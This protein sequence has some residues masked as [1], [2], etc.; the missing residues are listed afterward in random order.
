LTVATLGALFVAQR[1]KHQPPWLLETSRGIVTFAPQ[2][3]GTREAHFHIKTSVTARVDVAIVQVRTGHVIR[4]VAF[5][6]RMHGYRTYRLVWSGRTGSGQYASTGSYE[7]RVHFDPSGP[8]VTDPY[9]YLTLVR[10]SK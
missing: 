4:M 10:A 9:F 3:P 7:V 1:V 2:G 5:G 8:T 6:Y